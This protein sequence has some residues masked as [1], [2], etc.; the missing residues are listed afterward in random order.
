[1][2]LTLNIFKTKKDLEDNNKLCNILYYVSLNTG[3]Y[4]YT[5]I[6]FYNL[7]NNYHNP[8]YDEEVNIA[9]MVNKNYSIDFD[10]N[11][12]G[13]VYGGVHPL[14]HKYFISKYN[15]K[16]SDIVFEVTNIETLRSCLGLVGFTKEA[17]E[18]IDNNG[19]AIIDLCLDEDS[20]N[21]RPWI[22]IKKACYYLYNSINKD[23]ID[24]NEQIELDDI[25]KIYIDEIDNSLMIILSKN[26][27]I[28][29]KKTG[30]K[31]GTMPY[32]FD[33]LKNFIEFSDL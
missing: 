3:L 12:E 17:K 24:S 14:D 22:N 21:P 26:T 15:D 30:I 25:S 9:M 33:I 19:K 8:D 13:Y 16:Y 20:D 11:M 32:I 29:D 7:Y 4:I 28:I 23:K 6:E 31:Y 2:S 10:N 18:S 5:A 27:L 1:M